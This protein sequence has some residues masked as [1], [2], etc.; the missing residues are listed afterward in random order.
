MPG[1]LL[2]REAA[3]WAAAFRAAERACLRPPRLRLP[4]RLGVGARDGDPSTEEPAREL[5]EVA[6][7]LAPPAG[8]AGASIGLTPTAERTPC[9]PPREA[10]PARFG[11]D[12]AVR[13]AQGCATAAALRRPGS[14]TSHIYTHTYIYLDPRVHW[15]AIFLRTAQLGPAG[16]P[17]CPRLPEDPGPVPPAHLFGPAEGQLQ[18]SAA[19]S[20]PRPRKRLGGT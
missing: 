14:A 2:P 9:R 16:T 19:Q 4:E 6:L 3:A 13:G 10:A 20:R 15:A 8:V 1:G 18:V 7:E 5:A 11:T 12:C 17:P